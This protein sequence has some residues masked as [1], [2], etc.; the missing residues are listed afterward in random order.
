VALAVDF[1]LV[2]PGG[3]VDGHQEFRLALQDL[4]RVLIGV[5]SRRRSASQAMIY[6]AMEGS[7]L[8]A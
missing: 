8:D 4:C 5:G 6:R 1:A 3:E 7:I 2:V